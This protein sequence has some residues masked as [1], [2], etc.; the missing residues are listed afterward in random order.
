MERPA[1]SDGGRILK[2]GLLAFGALIWTAP[3]SAQAQDPLAPIS[4]PPELPQA[5]QVA[6]LAYKRGVTTPL[7][8]V[9]RRTLVN[10]GAAPVRYRTRP[11][12]GEPY[13]DELRIILDPLVKAD[14]A[15]GA[16]AQLLLYAP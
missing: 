5:E 1:A 3:L 10:L 2:A 12:Q 9:P 15:G 16:E 13:A 14:D 7:L 8:V 4:Q 11:V 6:T